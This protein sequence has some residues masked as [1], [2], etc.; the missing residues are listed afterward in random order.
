MMQGSIMFNAFCNAKV[1]KDSPLVPRVVSSM[2]R[3]V[4]AKRRPT[5]K[6]FQ[7]NLSYRTYRHL[8]KTG[9]LGE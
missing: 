5:D 8:V 9:V 2:E 4:K 7:A 6:P 1:E 3:H